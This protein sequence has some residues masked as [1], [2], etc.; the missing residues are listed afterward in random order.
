MINL[1]QWPDKKCVGV[2]V[3]C[4]KSAENTPKLL[5]AIDPDH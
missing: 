2:D 3:N 4:S 5:G 1:L